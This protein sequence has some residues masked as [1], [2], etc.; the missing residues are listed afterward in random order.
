M[1][2]EGPSGNEGSFL[3]QKMENAPLYHPPP[4]RIDEFGQG[5]SSGGPDISLSRRAANLCWLL[6]PVSFEAS[7]SVP[8]LSQ[9]R[10]AV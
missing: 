1:D 8:P 3:N 7:D 4:S 2:G 9:T 10:D 5:V 6:P